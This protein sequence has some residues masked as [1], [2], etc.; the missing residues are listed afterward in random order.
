M[1]FETYQAYNIWGHAIL[2]QEA[3]LRPERYAASGTITR[4][5]KVIE[6]SGV[7]GHF[8][9]EEEAQQSGLDWARAWVDSH[10]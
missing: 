5:N 1:E 8:N 4:G 7:L 10:G 9:T 2:Q 6:G 3:I